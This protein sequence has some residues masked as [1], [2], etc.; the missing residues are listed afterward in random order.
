MLL[1]TRYSVENFVG[2]LLM[3]PE[4]NVPSAASGTLPSLYMHLGR[5]IRR[6]H[7]GKTIFGAHEESVMQV[8]AAADWRIR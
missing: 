4:F 3:D 7:H 8:N 2:L 5:N 6:P 1:L